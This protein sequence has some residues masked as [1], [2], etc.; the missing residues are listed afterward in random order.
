VPWPNFVFIP[1]RLW[2]SSWFFLKLQHNDC[3]TWSQKL[4][5]KLRSDSGRGR[6]PT[7]KKL[8][9]NKNKKAIQNLCFCSTLMKSFVSQYVAE[10]NDF[11]HRNF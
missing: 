10:R 8:K 7:E 1:I 3:L 5:L 4:T 6:F 9:Q 11:Y 2:V